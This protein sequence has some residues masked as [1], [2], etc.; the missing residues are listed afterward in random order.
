MID[1]YSAFTYGHTVTDENKYL[2]FM[3]DGVNELSA[4]LAI[5]GYTLESFALEIARAMNDASITQEYVTTVN[6]VDGTITIESDNNFDLLITSGTQASISVFSLA[7]FT[8][9]DLTGAIEYTGN[10]RSGSLYRPQ[11]KLQS[12]IDF[13]D[14]RKT[15]N[16]KVNQSASGVV[17]VVS[18]GR[19]KFMTCNIDFIT[20]VTPQL[21]ILDNANGVGD[22]RQFIDYCT[23]KAPIEF[24]KDID[25]PSVFVDCL[26]ESTPES[27]DGVDYLIKELYSKGLAGYFESGTLVFR[28]LD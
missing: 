7:G 8:G 17:E 12:Y 9:A 16:S 6:R 21:H 10:N 26:L 22:Y 28:Q 27:K 2:N 13:Q 3:D 24:I 4:E 23:G 25:T 14:N 18:Y 15:L 5:G 11:R 19:V 1:T 20:D